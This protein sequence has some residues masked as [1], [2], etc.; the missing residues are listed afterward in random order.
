MYP[1]GI[2]LSFSSGFGFCLALNDKLTPSGWAEALSAI[3]TALAVAFAIFTY[4]SWKN[5]KIKQDAYETTRSYISTL[6][7]LEKTLIEITN[8]LYTISPMPGTI[9]PS[10]ESVKRTLNTIQ[11]KNGETRLLTQQLMSIESELQFWGVSLNKNA[12]EEHAIVINSINDYLGPLYYLHNS[13]SNIYIHNIDDDHTKWSELVHA[14][15]LIL[16]KSFD[17]RKTM[18]I[19]NMFIFK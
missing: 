4:K 11:E 7:S 6:S 12:K 19:H 9:V 14:Q 17:T 8:L 3:A 18:K 15:T 13:L 1:L 5:E 16:E 10:L 2:L